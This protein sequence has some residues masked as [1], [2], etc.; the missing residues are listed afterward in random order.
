M[1]D[2]DWLRGVGP[3]KYR[4]LLQCT[5]QNSLSQVIDFSTQGNILDVVLVN[6]PENILDL[7]SSG[8]S[9]GSDHE[10]IFYLILCPPVRVSKFMTRTM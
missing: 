2:V 8:Y 9:G 4:E 6:K 3:T 10:V 5:K 7:C 1:P